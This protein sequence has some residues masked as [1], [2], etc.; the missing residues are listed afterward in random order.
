MKQEFIKDIH[1]YLDGDKVVFTEAYF[2]KRGYCCGNKCR[3]CPYT[4]PAVKGN[5]ELEKS[6]KI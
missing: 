6:K 4:K 3:H 1:Y 2:L 5:K